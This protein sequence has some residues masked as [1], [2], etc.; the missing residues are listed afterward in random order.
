MTEPYEE[1]LAADIAEVY[2]QVFFCG[3]DGQIAC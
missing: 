2:L 3:K 1:T